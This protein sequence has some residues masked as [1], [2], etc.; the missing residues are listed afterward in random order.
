MIL[1]VDI[2]N[3]TTHL[4]LFEAGDGLEVRGHIR[5]A[6]AV[7]LGRDE[8]EGL[9][10]GPAEVDG[11]IISSVVPEATG[12]VRGALAAL[13]GVE[14]V[15]VG[16]E[17]L[18]SMP[19]LVDN[20][21]LVGTDRIVNAVAA[22]EIYGGP[23]IVVDLGTA[24]TFDHIT[25][26]GEFKGGVIAPGISTS[27]EALYERAAMLPEVE[28][29]RPALVVAPD[30]ATA[31]RSGLYWGFTALVDGIIER[32]KEEVGGGALVVATGGAARLIAEAAS[33]IDEV[34]E[35]LTLKGLKILGER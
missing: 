32:I 2:G 15:T 5:L 7:A 23:L 26:N 28:L 35:L 3:T 30:T 19:M 22:I 4:G 11:V 33:S 8:M 20:P 21:A 25:A 14:P 31:M 27:A 18:P 10:D 34:D 1:A 12:R 6:A 13:T 9:L 16:E 29:K 17:V 24:I